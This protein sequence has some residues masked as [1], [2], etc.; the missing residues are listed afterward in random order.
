[1]IPTNIEQTIPLSDPPALDS[2]GD[3]PNAQADGN[4]GTQRYGPRSGTGT[5]IQQS[6]GEAKGFVALT[7]WPCGCDKAPNPYIE[8]FATFQRHVRAGLKSLKS[9]DV[10]YES[11]EAL[12]VYWK[13]GDVPN[14][15]DKAKELGTV[16]EKAPYNF[17]VTP[18]EIDY[19]LRGHLEIEDGFRNAL[20][21]VERR[22][23]HLRDQ[24]KET[25]NL[26][27][28]YY[29]G[30][31][32]VDG[33]NRW[34]SP[35]KNSG[36]RLLWSKYQPRMYDLNCDILYL[37]DCC[38]SLAMVETASMSSEHRQRCEI[39]CSSGLK[40]QSGAQNKTL[41]TEALRQ[42]LAK[43]RDDVLD[44]VDAI[45]GLTFQN[46]CLT[47][48]G[49]ETRRNLLAEPRW[50]VVAPNPTVPG[51]I[52]LAMEK[53]GTE[54]ITPQPQRHDS[55]S[56]Y[57]SQIESFSQLSDTRILIKI[58][59]TNPAESLS[60]DDWLKWFEH[61][62]HNV[63]HVE[64]AVLKKIEWV[65]V[66]ESDSS[67]ALITVPLWL[68]Q[69]MEQD[70]ACESLG[71]VRSNNLVRRPPDEIASVLPVGLD[72]PAEKT[73]ERKHD[74]SLSDVPLTPLDTAKSA[75]RA[76]VKEHVQAK[77]GIWGNVK[78]I[79][80]PTVQKGRVSENKP[81]LEM[82]LMETPKRGGKKSARP[83][84]K[85]NFATTSILSM[86]L[87]DIGNLHKQVSK[88]LPDNMT[89]HLVQRRTQV[90]GQG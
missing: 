59:L 80:E 7:A 12:M 28:L 72:A 9:Q 47:M 88:M 19:Q 16:L 44:G 79:L 48:T 73:K 17:T 37:F 84:Q 50:Q 41:F 8:N 69:N 43:K 21:R 56:G 26:L 24:D 81:M 57:G 13:G 6:E 53:A 39:L 67:L 35:T 25:S 89:G 11:I 3:L 32:I 65:G 90:L 5:Q 49:E 30:H 63:A 46:I 14:L 82:E 36:K 60:S 77:T 4:Q 70:P 2:I 87:A 10:R 64:I 38:Y 66:F 20:N 68:W 52:T 74:K 75:K 1:M 55:D 86:R 15:A 34:W 29:G 51:K 62:P 85:N 22:L 45:G 61:R 78:N 40:E 58:R 31:G 76:V 42:L 18:H 54:A 83:Q 27:I 23:D 33:R 71:I